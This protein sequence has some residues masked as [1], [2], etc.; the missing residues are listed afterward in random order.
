MLEK[1]ER[2]LGFSKTV[3]HA[4]PGFGGRRRPSTDPGGRPRAIPEA[5]FSDLVGVQ[6]E[7][8]RPLVEGPSARPDAG[9]RLELLV[10]EWLQDL[11][12]LGRSERTI[13]WYQQKMRQYLATGGPASLSELTAFEFKRFLAEL[14]GRGLS[15]N[16]VHGFFEVIKA[17]G[18]WALRE[19]W[20]VDPALLR[21]RG[22]KV[23]VTEMETY[24]EAQLEAV[25]AAA[26]EGWP[27]M[28]VL[29]LLGTGMRLS[30]LCSLTLQDIEDDGEASFL[31]IQRGKGAKFRRVPVSRRLRKELVRYLNRVRPDTE[32]TQLLVRRD[33][34]PIRVETITELFQRIRKQSGF[35]VHAHK[36]R[37]TFATEYLRQGGEIERLRRI[38]GHT[39][40]VMV[41]RYVHLD[42]TDLYRDFDLR[43]PF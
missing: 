14:Q 20:E 22:P 12:V 1:S 32:S 16:T 29:T 2:P 18:N 13:G 17:F 8:L 31:K 24:S 39:S 19:G 37:H 9:P 28:A 3:G 6:P 30:E 41:M 40:Y 42:K 11:A 15:P 10:R 36:F 7:P 21:V 4:Q 27:R 43:S 25:L 33:G 5:G 23:P 38:L 34:K 35:P 26:P